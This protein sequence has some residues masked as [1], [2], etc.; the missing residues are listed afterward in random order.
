MIHGVP[1]VDPVR[2]DALVE[3]LEVDLEWSMMRV[4][5]GQ[6]RRVQLVLGLL[7]PFHCLLC[8]EVTVDLDVCARLDLLAFFK[9]ETEERGATIVYATH[10][11]DGL[12][13]WPTHVAYM[14]DGVMKVCDSVG[15]VPELFG[16]GMVGS[17]SRL[18]AT[19][20]EWLRRERDARVARG[21]GSLL[22]PK[23]APRSSGPVF[24]NRQMSHYR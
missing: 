22:L 17:Q 24:S 12:E 20:E 8:D 3:L 4:S 23:A 6:R 21:G 2:R 15:N 13:A 14:E 5:D 16:G 18:L 11:F 7:H 19:M 1:N 10:I 9:R